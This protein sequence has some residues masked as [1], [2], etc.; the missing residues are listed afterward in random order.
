MRGLAH[1]GKD[2]Q[3]K[4]TEV[5]QPRSKN[6]R[7]YA[8]TAKRELLVIEKITKTERP[9]RQGFTT[10]KH[11][12]RFLAVYVAIFTLLPSNKGWTWSQRFAI[13]KDYIPEAFND[14]WV[15]TGREMNVNVISNR[16]DKATRQKEFNNYCHLVP[17]ET[18]ALDRWLRQT[19]VVR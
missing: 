17:R 1:Y 12:P 7:V 5:T 4:L 10:A 9:T 19:G 3:T 15:Q 11:K 16:V 18:E 8:N 13:L 6:G 14:Y 2:L